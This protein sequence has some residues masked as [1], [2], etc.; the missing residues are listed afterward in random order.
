MRVK[1]FPQERNI[2]SL[3][4]THTLDIP[5]SSL[6][7]QSLKFFFQFLLTKYLSLIFNSITPNV[8]SLM[9]VILFKSNVSLLSIIIII[10]LF[11]ITVIRIV[12]ERLVHCYFIG[13]VSS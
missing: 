6:M 2:T 3:N 11:L 5:V 12:E 13:T 7:H 1:C 10:L 4:G 8:S 9:I